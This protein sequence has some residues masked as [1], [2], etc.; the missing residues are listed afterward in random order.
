MNRP[1]E[2]YA[3]FISVLIALSQTTFGH[4]GVPIEFPELVWAVCRV[5]DALVL[6]IREAQP[7]VRPGICGSLRAR[8][9]LRLSARSM[10]LRNRG[11]GLDD[12]GSQTMVDRRA[13]RPLGR[14]LEERAPSSKN[15]DGAPGKSKFKKA[16]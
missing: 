11:S 5:S 15:E 12:C 16:R 14:V 6:R 3:F 1:A 2:P 10:A 4:F 8:I 13:G 7:L 9:H